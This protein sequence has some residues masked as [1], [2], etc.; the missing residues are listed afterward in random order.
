MMADR[1]AVARNLRVR[2]RY[3]CHRQRQATARQRSAHREAHV[4]LLRDK[5]LCEDTV[6]RVQRQ[7]AAVLRLQYGLNRA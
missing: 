7:P 2:V 5:L 6:Q 1:T 3:P 4:R